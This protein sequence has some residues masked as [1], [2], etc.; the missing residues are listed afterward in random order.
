MHLS[1]RITQDIQLQFQT[2]LGIAF[3]AYWFKDPILSLYIWQLDHILQFWL[4]QQNISL[5]LLTQKPYYL[6]E[7]KYRHTKKP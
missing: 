1:Q 7:L 4:L 3:K 6:N 2:T 5:D